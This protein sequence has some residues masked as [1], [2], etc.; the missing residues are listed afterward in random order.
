M[1]YLFAAGVEVLEVDKEDDSRVTEDASKEVE[2]GEG[3]YFL[4][5]MVVNKK[6]V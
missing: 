4:V 3:Q 2:N 6:F 5:I 1:K